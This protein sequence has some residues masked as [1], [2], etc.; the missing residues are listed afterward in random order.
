MKP[1][2]RAVEI[3]MGNGEVSYNLQTKKTFLLIPYWATVSYRTGRAM[4]F[5]TKGDYERHI[6]ACEYDRLRDVEVSRTIIEIKG[7]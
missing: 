1:E 7:E 2:Y 4:M 3:L 6:R 5:E